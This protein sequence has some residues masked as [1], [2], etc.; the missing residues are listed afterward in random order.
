M[1]THLHNWTWDLQD[2][3]ESGWRCADCDH[4]P[5]EPAGYS[6]QLDRSELETKVYEVQA[7][8]HEEKL[9]RF[10]SGTEGMGCTSAVV[11]KCRATERFDQWS[12]AY[13]VF[14]YLLQGT[15]ADYWRDLGRAIVAGQDSRERCSC[16]ALAT[17]F[18]GV[19]KTRLAQC[20]PCSL[21]REGPF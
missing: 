4:Q 12:I 7:T 16:G 15:H 11:A 5:G 13:F 2:C 3:N 21:S 9:G 1:T 17:S 6:P 19:G 20:G 10:S 18:L 8:I 14:E